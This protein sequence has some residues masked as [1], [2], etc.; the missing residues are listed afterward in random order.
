MRGGPAGRG[1]APQGDAGDH[2]RGESRS[3]AGRR[4]GRGTGLGATV[5]VAAVRS[6]LGLEAPLPSAEVL[7][8]AAR[9][10]G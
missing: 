3:L 1:G 7:E 6:T 5:S 10:S 2:A 9:L 8:K 4:H